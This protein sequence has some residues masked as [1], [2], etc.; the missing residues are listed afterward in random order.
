M[1]LLRMFSSLF[2]RG[3]TFSERDG[4]VVN[5]EMSRVLADARGEMRNVPL[6]G[7]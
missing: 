2:I 5:A 7:H 1:E 6:A 3:I 4:M